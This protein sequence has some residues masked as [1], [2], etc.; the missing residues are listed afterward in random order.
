MQ[1]LSNPNFFFGYVTGSDIYKLW[2]SL[3]ATNRQ[4]ITSYKI[5]DKT[6]F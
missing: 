5:N 2:A 1:P 3:D 4:F 6:K